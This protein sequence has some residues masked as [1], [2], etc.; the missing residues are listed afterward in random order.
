MQGSNLHILPNKL[1]IRETF[2]DLASVMKNGGVVTGPVTISNSIATFNSVVGNVG[3]IHYNFRFN[4]TVT[5]RYIFKIN[6]QPTQN[7]YIAGVFAGLNGANGL[8]GSYISSSLNLVNLVTTTSIYINGIAVSSYTFS[9][10]VWYE[11]T[12]VVTRYLTPYWYSYVL[13]GLDIG[14]YSPAHSSYNKISVKLAE[15][16]NYS[17]SAAEVSDLYTQ[18]LYNDPTR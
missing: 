18:T 5:I 8:G 12:E 17:L 15:V 11:L 7:F 14:C 16:Y 6:A 9:I 10:G 1:I 2:Q 3:N 4:N 13:A